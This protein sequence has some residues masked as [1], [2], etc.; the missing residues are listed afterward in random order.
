M[1]Q[2]ITQITRPSQAVFVAQTG[3][4]TKRSEIQFDQARRNQ[5]MIANPKGGFPVSPKDSAPGILLIGA[6]VIET[7]LIEPI[8]SIRQKWM[9]R[10]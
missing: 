9:V 10:E 1:S 2:K 8:Q 6:A 3:S 7:V 4:T 5:A